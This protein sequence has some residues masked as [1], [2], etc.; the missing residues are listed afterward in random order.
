MLF[1]DSTIFWGGFFIFFGV[2]IILKAIFKIDI[3]LVKIVL[4][5]FCLYCGLALLLD[6]KMLPPFG[7]KCFKVNVDFNRSKSE[8]KN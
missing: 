7:E 5:I 4:G 2:A 1:I 8:K 6:Q 3:P